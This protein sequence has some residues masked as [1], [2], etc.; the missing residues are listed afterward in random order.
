V[1]GDAAAM[2]EPGL[3]LHEWETRW[4]ELE[5]LIEDSPRESLPELDRLVEGI[6]EARGFAPND[7][8]A[9]QGD[10]PEILANF[11]AARD[12]MLRSE[13]FADIS[14]GDVAQAIEDYRLVYETVIQQR[15]A[16]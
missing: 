9:A 15:A 2:L 5:P 16:P 1:N 6:L 13:S 4:Q 14:P 7:P 10:E 12:I 3:D 8:V 11:R